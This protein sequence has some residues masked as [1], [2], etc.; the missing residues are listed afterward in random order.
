MKAQT[1]AGSAQ[2]A[3]GTGPITPRTGPSVR[4]V[5]SWVANAGPSSPREA[6][7]FATRQ[8]AAWN[9]DSDGDLELLVSELV[10]NAHRHAEG[11]VTVAV[12]LELRAATLIVCICDDGPGM[13]A[14]GHSWGGAH[15]NEPDLRTGGY[16]LMLLQEMALSTRIES[17]NGGTAIWFVLPR[18]RAR[19]GTPSPLPAPYP[20]ERDRND[21]Y[22]PRPSRHLQPAVCSMF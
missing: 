10:T 1:V 12:H 17:D 7:E 14:T 5:S 16:G 21:Q 11:R 9:L 6:R 3:P 22:C 20:A 8:V 19:D 2:R 15:E 4:R 18:P 13:A